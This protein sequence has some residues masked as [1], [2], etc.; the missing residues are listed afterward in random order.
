MAQKERE[1]PKTSPFGWFL[2][3]GGFF[4][5]ER[6][7]APTGSCLSSVFCPPSLWNREA[8]ED[9][10]NTN[11]PTESVHEIPVITM[12]RCPK[13]RWTTNNFSIRTNK[14]SQGVFFGGRVLKG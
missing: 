5:R 10:V 1:N 9:K 3:F 12:L 2:G 4:E 14:S 6:N 8:K 11:L 13:S 7:F